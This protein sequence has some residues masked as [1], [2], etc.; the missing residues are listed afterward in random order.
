MASVV[1]SRLRAG[2]AVGEIT[3]GQDCPLHGYDFRAAGGGAGN[4]GV[5]DPLR[6]RV[7]VLQRGGQRGVVA[8]LDCAL[9]DTET[10]RGYRQGIAEALGTDTEHVIVAA[11]HT[12][13]GAYLATHSLPSTLR[14]QAAVVSATQAYGEAVR[15]KVIET[16]RRA[17]GLTF[18]VQLYHREAP[19][20]LGY[21]RRVITP[22]GL[23]NCWSPQEWPDRQPGPSPDPT[24]SVVMLKESVGARS[25][26][27][28]NLGVHPVVLGK[29]SNEVSA[30]YPGRACEMI[31]EYIPG[32][33][34]LFLLGGAANV[35]PWV[36]TQEDPK[37]VDVVGRCAASFVGLLSQGMA[38]AQDDEWHTAA[39]TVKIGAWDVDLCIWK[40]GPV[41]VVA[42]PVELFAE[43]GADLR[44]RLK[45]PLLLATMANGAC[46]YFPTKAAFAEG[47]Y[48]TEHL[49]AGKIL[50]PG[51]GERL[52]D[53]VVRLAET[54]KE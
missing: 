22:E 54:I 49:G 24:C 18:P 47:G 30:D 42:L 45:G 13:S 51:D 23:R 31:G 3:P 10:A 29:T 11:T 37:Q 36:A 32:S 15:R 39:A 4:D 35:H 8:S 9:I 21:N 6:V 16:A 26:I 19:F 2:F 52:V 27:L 33:S 41:R 48:E 28:W 46:G 40:I 12:H 34:S 44:R 5:L 53:E 43:L 25:Y 38:P 1:G 14:T 17:G 50:A 7:M 20:G